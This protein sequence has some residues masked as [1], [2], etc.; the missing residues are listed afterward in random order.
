MH[1]VCSKS[2]RTVDDL[3]KG[4]L[5]HG[6]CLRDWMYFTPKG[7]TVSRSCRPNISAGLFRLEGEKRLEEGYSPALEAQSID[8]VFI[9]VLSNFRRKNKKQSGLLIIV[10]EFDQIKNKDGLGS[11]F[12]SVSSSL[13][14]VKFC[15]VGVAQDVKDLINDHE[16]ISRTFSGSTICLHPMSPSELS[17]I[18]TNAE[19]SIGNTIHFEMAARLFLT[20]LSQGQ[21]YMVQLVGKEALKIAFNTRQS[22][23]TIEDVQKARSSLIKKSPEP[24]LEMRYQKA[25]GQSVYRE[26]VLRSLAEA[27]G[28]N[29]SIASLDAYKLARSLKVENPGKYAGQLLLDKYGAEL[30]R[31]GPHLYRF[32]DPLFAAFAKIRPLHFQTSLFGGHDYDGDLIGLK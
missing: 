21:P 11:L 20:E 18:V 8:S 26:L 16:S 2:V 25:I 30:A 17:E 27:L 5:S 29:G 15:I 32:K 4:I 28:L 3:I 23:V 9:N 12:K 10:D 7:A 13:P 19:S 14:S 24:F 1:Y 6:E 22:I 31:E